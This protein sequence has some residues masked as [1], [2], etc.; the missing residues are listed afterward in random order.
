MD[1]KAHC[2]QHGGVHKWG[3]PHSWMVYKGNS[4]LKMD[5][6]GLPPFMETTSSWTSFP[7]FFGTTTQLLGQA[8]E[9]LHFELEE[10]VPNGNLQQLLWNP[11]ISMAHLV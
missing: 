4:Q 7:I 2:T 3:Y 9:A 5:N 8:S 10:R 6:L 1:R 11:W